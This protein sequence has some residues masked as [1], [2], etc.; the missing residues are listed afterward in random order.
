MDQ[1]LCADADK[2]KRPIQA[3]Q[4]DAVS[5]RHSQTVAESRAEKTAER[6]DG[7]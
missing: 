1:L 2:R 3:A 7:E 4:E 6:S 5:V